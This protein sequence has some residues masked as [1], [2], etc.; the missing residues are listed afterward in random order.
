M[1]DS[2]RTD[3]DLKQIDTAALAQRYYNATI[4]A[5]DRVTERLWRI[6]VKP[7]DLSL[8]YKA[9]QYLVL[10]LG[11][12]QERIDG[13]IEADIEKRFSRLA[14]RA[15]SISSPL[16][17]SDGELF[18]PS[19][20]D[21][22]E[23]YIVLVESADP[24]AALTPRLALCNIGARIFVA[25]R[26][27]GLYSLDAIEDPDSNCVFISTGTGEAPHLAMVNQLLTDRHRGQILS[28]STHQRWEDFAY[29][30]E[31]RR[32]EELFENYSYL[33]LPTRE[34]DIA[35]RYPQDVLQDGSLEEALG[36]RFDP[37]TTHVFLC[38]SPAMIGPAD[39]DDTWP[40][41][42]GMCQLLSERGFSFD[43]RN[44]LGNVHFETYWD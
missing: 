28:V 15:Y 2:E 21:E 36:A 35:K 39:R 20:S 1:A 23:F 8:N 14:K 7:D 30:H 12:W 29:L 31:N 42:V 13:L 5:F 19:Q 6:R 9:G 41:P 33:A 24:L 16:I 3:S 43:S 26:I 25:K 38:G 32:C 44:A 27:R 10:G 34:P 40:K 22:L 17:G 11:F 4:T 18:D 37:E